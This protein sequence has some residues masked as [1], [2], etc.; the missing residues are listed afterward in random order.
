MECR[1][2][3]RVPKADKGEVIKALR[4]GMSTEIVAERFGLSKSRVRA[5][6]CEAGMGVT[7]GGRRAG[8]RSIDNQA[9]VFGKYEPP[10]VQRDDFMK[11]VYDGKCVTMVA[12]DAEREEF[13]IGEGR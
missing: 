4:D 5:M 8:V 6:R 13:G 2:K 9:I 12:T 1:A 11:P 10:A 3:G 7:T